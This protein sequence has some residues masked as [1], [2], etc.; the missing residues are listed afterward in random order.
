MIGDRW[1]REMKGKERK[2]LYL[3]DLTSYDLELVVSSIDGTGHLR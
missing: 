2:G 3:I 1:T